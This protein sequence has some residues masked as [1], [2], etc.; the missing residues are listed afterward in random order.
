MIEGKPFN[1]L[2]AADDGRLKIRHG[3]LLGNHWNTKRAGGVLITCL[4]IALRG[5]LVTTT[6]VAIVAYLLLTNSHI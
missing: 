4:A 2:A 6:A 1:Q 3:F 5:L